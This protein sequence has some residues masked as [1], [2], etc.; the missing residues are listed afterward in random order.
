MADQSLKKVKKSILRKVVNE[1]NLSVLLESD[2]GQ[3]FFNQYIENYPELKKYWTFYE[4][5]NEITTNQNSDNLWESLDQ[6]F[7]THVCISAED[8]V[9][10]CLKDRSVGETLKT[11]INKKDTEDSLK[12]LKCLQKLAYDHL[13]K[14][15][16]ELLTPYIN[17]EVS[18]RGSSKTCDLS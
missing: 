4:C 11:A 5:V 1:S 15:A 6:C 12:Q 14:R 16:L 7:K 8:R 17:S 18:S 10:E 13:N 3:T 2:E 9:D